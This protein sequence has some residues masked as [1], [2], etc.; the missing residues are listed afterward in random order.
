[1][2]PKFILRSDKTCPQRA[3]NSAQI[4]YIPRLPQSKRFAIIVRA[5]AS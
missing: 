4:V 5:G 2:R 1:M 3:F